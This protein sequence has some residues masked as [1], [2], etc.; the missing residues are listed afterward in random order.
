MDVPKW[1]LEP[2]QLLDKGETAEALEAR[3]GD[4]P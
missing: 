2:L 1:L 3:R 4:L